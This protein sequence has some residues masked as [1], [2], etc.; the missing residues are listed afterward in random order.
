[1]VFELADAS[2]AGFIRQTAL[3][4]GADSDSAGTR[5]PAPPLH[6]P[7]QRAVLPFGKPAGE[8]QA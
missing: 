3:L 6:T 4:E 1:M 5:L 7:V 2:T 8:L